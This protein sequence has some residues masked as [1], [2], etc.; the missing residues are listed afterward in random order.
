MGR[1]S[2]GQ[3]IPGVNQSEQ[4][5]GSEMV[6]GSTAKS[7]DVQSIRSTAFTFETAVNWALGLSTET[8]HGGLRY[9]QTIAGC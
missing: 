8:L 7:K 4:T 3:D 6:L 5:C 2:P 9:R 1:T